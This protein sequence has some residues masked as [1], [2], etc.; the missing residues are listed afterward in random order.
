MTSRN[1]SVAVQEEF[2]VH[3]T[4]QF[5]AQSGYKVRREVPNMGQSADL[6]ATRGRWVTFIEAKTKNWRRALQQCRAHELVADFVC[7]AI[8]ANRRT[9]EVPP[10]L[11]ESG[12]G[13]LMVCPRDG[14]CAWHVR[15]MLN[16]SVWMPQ[17]KRMATSLRRIEY[18][19]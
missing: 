7:V 6:V 1:R 19:G 18:E 2:V 9:G 10:P 16:R 17:R 5:L 14:T 8:L 11:L 13:I 4:T 12:Y 3:A 15:P